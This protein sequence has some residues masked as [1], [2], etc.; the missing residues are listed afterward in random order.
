MGLHYLFCCIL[1]EILAK[2]R[3]KTA[4][5]RKNN[6]QNGEFMEIGEHNGIIEEI[7]LDGKSKTGYCTR[8]RF[9]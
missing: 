2:N 8:G 6:A 4:N 7:S 3:E 5:A 9:F 1:K